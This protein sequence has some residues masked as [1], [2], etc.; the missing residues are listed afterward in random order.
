MQILP[1]RPTG[2]SDQF[3]PP[4]ARATGFMMVSYSMGGIAPGLVEALIPRED[5]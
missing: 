4:A 5:E 2:K 3:G 1:D